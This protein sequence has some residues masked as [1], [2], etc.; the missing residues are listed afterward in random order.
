M[1]SVPTRFWAVLALTLCLQASPGLSA[2]DNV[3]GE[4]GGKL[5]HKEIYRQTLRSVGKISVRLPEGSFS[6]T[7]WVVDQKK[8]LMITNHH[9]VGNADAALVQF[10]K[11]DRRGKVLS[12]PRDYASKEAVRAKVLDS[13]P[14]CDLAV[15]QLE[16]LPRGV[17]E[18]TLADD[19]PENTDRLHSIGNPGAS[20]GMWVYTKGAVRTVVRRQIRYEGDQVVN[21]KVVETTSPINPGDSGGPIVNDRGQLVAVVSGYKT[22]AQLMSFGIDVTEV[23]AFLKEVRA[24]MNPRTAPAAAYH[25]RGLRYLA[26]RR[27]DR[28][29]ADFTTALKRDGKRA[30]SYCGRG[31]AFLARRDYDTAIADLTEALKLDPKATDAYYH[32]ALAQR[33][34]KNYDQAIADLTQAIRLA[35]SGEVLYYERGMVYRLKGDLTE[36]VGNFGAALRLNAAYLPAYK[37]R[38]ECYCSLKQFDKAIADYAAVLKRHDRDGESYFMLA[39]IFYGLEKFDKTVACCTAALKCD[40]VDKGLVYRLR[41]LG[42]FRS[43][44]YDLALV[45]FN[46]ALG[47]NTKDAEAY[48]FRGAAYEAKEDLVKADKDYTRAVQLDARYNKQVPARKSC[49]FRVVNKTG[50][51]LTIYLRY[52]KWTKKSGWSWFPANRRKPYVVFRANNGQAAVLTTPKGVPIR[53]R[54]ITLVGVGS[55]GGK[56]RSTLKV[57]RVN[58]RS[59]KPWVFT[60]TLNP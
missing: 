12:D 32:R 23:K 60:L 15:L 4:S 46:A 45:D 58:F 8:R 5:S 14:R 52:E 25:G 38:A 3:R 16:T 47:Q 18:L 24:L 1:R 28:A 57:A 50:Q 39:G 54:H 44:N 33:T 34:K 2:E 30:D 55:S 11:Y 22:G 41:G 20:A 51:N 59:R 27:F 37:R 36:A 29:V 26:K 31:Q 13:D 42:H 6:G 48:F 9:V 19:S 40:H 56:W 53:C 21:C 35:P 49:Y 7:G 10:P 43:Q 17:G